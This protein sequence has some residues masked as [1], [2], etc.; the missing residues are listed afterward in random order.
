[1]CAQ[2]AS[3]GEHGLRAQKEASSAGHMTATGSLP[4]VHDCNCIPARLRRPRRTLFMHKTCLT[5]IRNGNH[6]PFDSLMKAPAYKEAHTEDDTGKG[7]QST[8]V[9]LSMCGVTT[10]VNTCHAVCVWCHRSTASSAF[11]QY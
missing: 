6:K 5:R 7:R 4:N 10:S 1:M 8:P 9:T 3:I 2:N 11:L